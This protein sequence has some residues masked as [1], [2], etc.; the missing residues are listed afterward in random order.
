MAS[1]SSSVPQQC[2]TD[3]DV[4]DVNDVNDVGTRSGAAEGDGRASSHSGCV[5]VRDSLAGGATAAESTRQG[6]CLD[7]DRRPL[8]RHHNSQDSDGDGDGAVRDRG[9]EGNQDGG[10]HDDDDGDEDVFH[11]A[12]QLADET[13]LEG[14]GG[15]AAL[16][17]QDTFYG[18]MRVRLRDV[19]SLTL[20]AQRATQFDNR[21]F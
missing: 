2:D 21:W 17:H 13:D 6:L 7:R 20:A 19:C 12:L 4:N 8:S 5:H 18:D 16:V 14:V 15:C 3:A 1:N 11:S 10:D 9:R